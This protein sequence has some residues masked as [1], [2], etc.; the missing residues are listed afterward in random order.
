MNYVRRSVIKEVCI[1]HIFGSLFSTVI[2]TKIQ[3]MQYKHNNLIIIEH[4][5]YVSAN[6]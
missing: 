2:R 3:F 5:L 1:I 4:R 6:I